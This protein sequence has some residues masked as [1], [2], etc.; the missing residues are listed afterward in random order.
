MSEVEKRLE[1]LGIRLPEVS[2][3]VASYVPYVVFGNFVFVSGNLPFES[4]ELKIKGRLGE[5]VS[6]E[7]GI[8]AARICAVNA[9]ASLKHAV[10][11]LDKVAAIVRVEGFVASTPEFDQHPKVVN[12]ASELI[13]QVFGE[14]GVHSRFAVGCASLPLGAPVEIGLIAAVER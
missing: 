9:L 14:K 5:G 7:E 10:G 3:P 12:G 11:D 2:K 1:V 6:L 8:R 13:V 4:G